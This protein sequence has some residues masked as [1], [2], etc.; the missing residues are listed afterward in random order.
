MAL[1]IF[2]VGAPHLY[3]LQK[4][5]QEID[6]YTK[7]SL[8]IH[9]K[10]EFNKLFEYLNTKDLNNYILIADYH[11]AFT[12]YEKGY[13]INYI[14]MPEEDVDIKKGMTKDPYFNIP[15][16]VY[17]RDFKG[18]VENQPRIVISR[19]YEK[20]DALENFVVRYEEFERPRVYR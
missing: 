10:M 8:G 1:I 19:D 18:I 7:T 9:K 14:L 16:T 4:E 2:L 17:E 11:S 3:L 15:Y 20:F 12:L 6:T 13:D 5:A